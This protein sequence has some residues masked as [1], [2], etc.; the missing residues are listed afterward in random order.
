MP[1]KALIRHSG[2]GGPP[3]R[4][5]ATFL[6]LDHLMQTVTPETVRHHASGI[7]VDDLNL[8]LDDDILFTLAEK[9]DRRQR[10]PGEFFTGDDAAP[11]R[12]TPFSEFRDPLLTFGRQEY[13]PLFDRQQI[14]ETGL[15]RRGQLKCSRDRV[16]IDF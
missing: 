2:N 1:K 5:R 11:G 12:S 9:M 13:P 16:V 15:E 14:V 3:L 7:F 6:V 8:V 10:L 4:L